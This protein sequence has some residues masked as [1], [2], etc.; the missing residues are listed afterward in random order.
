MTYTAIIL[1][2]AQKVGVPAAL[3][4]AICSQESGLRNV[5][6]PHDNGSPSYGLCQLKLDTAKGLGYQG[7]GKGL[8][9]PETNAS[10]AGKYLR[11]QLDRYNGDWCSA[12]AAFNAGSYLPSTKSPGKPKNFKY[13]RKVT[14]FLDEEHKDFLVC[15]PRKVEE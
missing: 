7:D 10:F 13:V 1:A 5:E 3:L 6:A 12:T 2:A 8:M 9:N 11:Y 4:L 15:G 14:L